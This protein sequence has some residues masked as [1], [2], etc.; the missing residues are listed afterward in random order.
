MQPYCWSHVVM[1]VKEPT[2]SGQAPLIINT[3]QVLTN[4]EAR[5]LNQYKRLYNDYSM[6]AKMQYGLTFNNAAKLNSS[7]SSTASEN[8]Y[9][10][11]PA[12]SEFRTNGNSPLQQLVLNSNNTRSN[13]LPN[14]IKKSKSCSNSPTRSYPYQLPAKSRLNSPD[15]LMINTTNLPSPPTTSTIS[16]DISPIA[17]VLNKS[18]F[19]L[20]N[21]SNNENSNSSTNLTSEMY[22]TSTGQ[23]HLNC[24]SPSDQHHQ[25]Q[26]SGHSLQQQLNLNTM[27]PLNVNSDASSLSQC[28]T[29]GSQSAFHTQNFL[30]QY[31][32]QT[33]SLTTP[34]YT[35]P[36]INT[37]SNN[38]FTHSPQHSSSIIINTTPPATPPEIA[39][40]SLNSNSSSQNGLTLLNSTNLNSLNSNSTQAKTASNKRSLNSSSISSSLNS[41]SSIN[42]ARHSPEPKRAYLGQNN[43]SY[44]NNSYTNIN[45]YNYN[46]QC[47]HLSSQSNL[48]NNN[49]K[50]MQQ[51]NSQNNQQT[52]S[53]NQ[54]ANA[55][56]SNLTQQQ[57]S[58]H[59]NRWLPI[60]ANSFSDLTMS[61]YYNAAAQLNNQL[62]QAAV[63]SST[64]H[65]LTGHHQLNT[66]IT[67][68]QSLP[69]SVS[70]IHNQAY[71]PSYHSYTN[72]H[73]LRTVAELS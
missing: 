45:Y 55:N 27:T 16:P 66:A 32:P 11:S 72:G 50:L 25:Q 22:L 56:A 33:G 52:Q 28:V 4:R 61:N 5:V 7:A 47:N 42:S 20:T 23:F 48:L 69:N 53:V 8:F 67:H 12:I 43:S 49:S 38:L 63:H 39:N 54:L 51:V 44:Y 62:N 36:F 9:N 37:S 64:A 41:T 57:Y 10:S 15:Q 46:S 71:H 2:E 1:Q 17:K 58:L 29:A 34:T 60:T 59:H 14:G 31:S 18:K 35:S 68:Q 6:H 19:H 13:Q 26:T 3:I 65:Q 21:L 70:S 40:H 30:Q 73:H 24:L